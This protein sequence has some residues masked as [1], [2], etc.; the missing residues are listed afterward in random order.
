M[1]QGFYNGSTV[2]KHPCDIED[3]I[4]R[5]HLFN[6]DKMLVTASTINESRDHFQLCEKYSNQFNSTAGVHPCSVAKEF[7]QQ[8]EGGHYTNQLRDDVD[9]KLQELKNILIKGHQLGYVKALGEIGLDYDRLHYSTKEQQI[10]MFKRQLDLLRELP[11]KIPLFLHM[12]AACDDFV[13]II[14]PYIDTGIIER[15]KGVVHSFTGSK[16]ELQ[17]ILDLG[18]FI[19]VNGCSLKTQENVEVASKIPIDKL[20][21]E[22]DAPWCG[23]RKSHASYKYLTPYPNKFYP[24]IESGLELNE[25]KPVFQLDD[26][27]PFPSIKKEAYEKHSNY[28]SQ[29]SN[30]VIC[31]KRNIGVFSKPMIKSRNEPVAVGLVAEVLA[32]IHG[33][34]EDKEIEN[35]IDTIFENSE[36]LFT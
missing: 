7:Y 36:K 30:S 14:Q 6:V 12:R 28:V 22:T 3:V 19:G 32:K 4:E 20:M 2:S 27:L 9:E 18:F 35:F 31:I 8:E 11:F 1:F 26:H 17:K 10:E 34:E 24:E 21:I 25:A 15:G 13:E 29:K 16:S 5:A 23:I 33:I